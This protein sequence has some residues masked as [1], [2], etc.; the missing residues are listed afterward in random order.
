MAAAMS[1]ARGPKP[2]AR[3][4]APARTSKPPEAAAAASSAPHRTWAAIAGSSA[5]PIDIDCRPPAQDA[6]ITV[7][8]NLPGGVPAEQARD[9]LELAAPP[10]VYAAAAEAAA[11]AGQG[12]A[13]SPHGWC[14]DSAVIH[15]RDGVRYAV[16]MCFSAPPPAIAPL[17]SALD[18]GHRT[19]ALPAPW[20][21]PSPHAT[22]FR[23]DAAT[24]QEARLSGV[25]TALPEAAVESALRSQFPAILSARRGTIACGGGHSMAFQ[26]YTLMLDRRR[27][28]A[29]PV[30]RV[31]PLRVGGEV[32]A[33]AVLYRVALASTLQG[34][35]P[36]GNTA[37]P[38]APMADA[39]TPATAPAA[40]SPPAPA[41]DTAAA[42]PPARPHRRLPTR[43]RG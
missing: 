21:A 26:P 24:Q 7:F 32:V 19:L 5:E 25:P 10:A 22:L 15:T 35:P 42:T 6:R 11:T 39:P 36:G 14:A 3:R 12:A 27:D 40:T 20:P 37:S 38:P 4:S 18:R 43:P 13:S 23:G 2:P 29:K 41:A 31:L 28:L 8:V 9:L 30:P 1:G 16:S 17:T 34:Q 33:Q